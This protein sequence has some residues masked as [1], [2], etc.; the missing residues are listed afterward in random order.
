MMM[1]IDAPA[2]RTGRRLS[3]HIILQGL[4]GP[5]AAC[6]MFR[7]LG[8]VTAG[9]QFRNYLSSAGRFG[10]RSLSRES[11][12]PSVRQVVPIPL[13]LQE[14][15]LVE[16]AFGRLQ[17]AMP[18]HDARSFGDRP[19]A[20]PALQP[21]DVSSPYHFGEPVLPEQPRQEVSFRMGEVAFD[22]DRVIRQMV[23][24]AAAKS[25]VL[26]SGPGREDMGI[27]LKYTMNLPGSLMICLGE[28][29][30]VVPV[31]RSCVTDQNGAYLFPVEQLPDLAFK[32]VHVPLLD[33]FPCRPKG[34]VDDISPR[35]R[36]CDFL[37]GDPVGLF[38]LPGRSDAGAGLGA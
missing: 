5:K 35:L 23:E 16:R 14:T 19:T 38:P 21:I 13:A 15:R 17:F 2:L 29:V 22:I 28:A 4:A 31:E 3:D 26:I 25:R 33:L 30:A 36:G 8:R 10:S 6:G 27:A 37:P 11:Q 18:F 12:R 32:N 1:D 34:R 20:L 7:Q 9:C 24:M